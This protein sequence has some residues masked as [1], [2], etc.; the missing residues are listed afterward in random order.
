MKNKINK[1]KDLLTYVNDLHQKSK[2]Q[3]QGGLQLPWENIGPGYCYGPA[4][5][6]WDAVHAAMDLLDHD[7]QQSIWQIDNLLSLQQEDGML[8]S[9]LWMREDSP[10]DWA[11]D[12]T[13]PPVWVVAADIIYLR[14]HDKR[15]LKKCREALVKQIIWFENNRKTADRGFYY[16]DIKNHLWESGI[17]EGIRYKD[18]AMGERSCIDATSHVYLMYDSLIR[19]DEKL[20]IN[21]EPGRKER[22]TEL[23]DYLQNQLFDKDTSWFYDEWT[24]KEQ[25]YRHL[26]FEGLWPVIVGA[27]SQEQAAAVIERH[28]MNPDQFLSAHPVP[29]VSMDDPGYE[30]RMWRGPAW[31]SMT[32]WAAMGCMRYGRYQEAAQIL[33]AALDDTA[34]KLEETGT[35]WEFYDS[36]GGAPETVERKPHTEFNMPCCDY[37]GHNPVNYMVHLWKLCRENMYAESE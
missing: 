32:M 29:T 7:L 4:F 35:I 31:N 25:K 21:V 2:L 1:W 8:P 22:R 11:P 26:C 30:K 24:I 33:E 5:G 36:Q 27:A 14:T 34:I 18:I 20:E 6:H 9:M 23:K 16:S 10:A 17:D 37:L 12:Q 19:W 3:P 28:L 15:W 13:H